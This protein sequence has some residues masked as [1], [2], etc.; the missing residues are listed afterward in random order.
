MLCRQQRWPPRHPEVSSRAYVLARVVQ[1]SAG[2]D[3]ARRL[4]EEVKQYQQARC[5]GT[6]YEFA[7]HPHLTQVLGKAV[8]LYGFGS[9]EGS[10][11]TVLAGI[12]VL[13]S[14]FTQCSVDT[15]VPLSQLLPLLPAWLRPA[16]EQPE[17]REVL[18][19]LLTH[20]GVT[21][22]HPGWMSEQGGPLSGRF[23]VRAGFYE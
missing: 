4:S 19:L 23:E 12:T 17:L 9:V 7:V 10:P 15:A 18:P 1:R 6:S 14:L 16:L 13:L 22:Y 11:Y 2:Q 20:T 3:G 8:C 5:R 21:V